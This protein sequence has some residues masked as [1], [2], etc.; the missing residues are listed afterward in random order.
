MK[1]VLL[2]LTLAFALL[3]GVAEARTVKL[4]VA[5]DPDLYA[6][7]VRSLPLDV[8]MT[9]DSWSNDASPEPFLLKARGFGVTPMITWEPWDPVP[10]GSRIV[11]QPAWSNASIASGR[12]DAYI[13]RYARGMKDYRRP[14]YVR[15]AHEMNGVWMPWSVDPP[16]YVAAW[17]HVWRIFRQEGATNVR[18]IWSINANGFQREGDFLRNVRRYWP[19]SRYVD[20]IGSTLVQF[21]SNYKPVP[22]LLDR[23]GLLRSYG[24]PIMLTEVKVYR[25]MRYDWLEDLRCG[26]ARRPWIT[27]VI[28]SETRSRAQAEGKANGMEWSILTDRRARAAVSALRRPKC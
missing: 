3:P 27:G 21:K 1:R 11:P 14:V 2:A 26:L 4:G 28:W 16:A 10:F 15:Y 25:P 6:Q 17:R 9:Y 18:W 20:V 19:G 23:I 12:H 7:L 24:K 22:W 8:R 5:A 13:R